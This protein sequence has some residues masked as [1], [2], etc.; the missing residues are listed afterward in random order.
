MLKLEASS[1]RAEKAWTGPTVAHIDR[2]V[3][4]LRWTDRPFRFHANEG[5]EVFAVMAGAVDMHVRRSPG[6]DAEIVRLGPGDI[7]HLAEGE[8]HSAHPLGEACVLIV[9]QR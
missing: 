6:V 4:K 7:L 2:A 9:E 1:F 8:E 3:V 5:D